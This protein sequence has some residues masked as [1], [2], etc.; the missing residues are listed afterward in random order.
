MS[1]SRK[2]VDALLRPIH[3]SRVLRDNK[4]MSH[5]SQQDVRAHL[6]RIFGFAGWSSEV[7]DLTLVREAP[8]MKDGKEKGWAVTYRAT[9]R[10][11]VRDPE[12]APLAV[13]EDVA[14]GT[15]PNLPTL[16]DAHDFACK[17]AV[18]MALK[19]AATCLG[20]GFGLSLYNKGQTSA[21]VIGTLVMPGG[22]G[23]DVSDAVPQQES[24]GHDDAGSAEPPPGP[25]TPPPVVPSTTDAVKAAKRDLWQHAQT[26]GMDAAALAD[27]FAAWSRGELLADAD[28][29][30]VREFLAHLT[31]AVAS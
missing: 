28:E 29:K 5:V 4:G 3:A 27:A 1:L 20:D 16:G 15:S 25:P 13:Y 8:G 24:L 10:L 17:V 9:V 21:L 26:A 19:R 14:T 22:E 6:S 30:A 18:S 23:T 11:T 7:V 12:G 2:Q 31:A